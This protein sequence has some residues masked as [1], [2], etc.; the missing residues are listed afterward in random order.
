MRYPPAHS[1][2]ASPA[3]ATGG[4]AACSARCPWH[5]VRRARRQPVAGVPRSTSAAQADEHPG[6]RPREGRR[7]PTRVLDGAPGPLE[8]KPV[9]WIHQTSLLR[10]DAEKS[11]VKLIHVRN[12][13]T[14]AGIGFAGLDQR[15]AKTISPVKPIR[16]NLGD[17]IPACRQVLPKRIQVRRP[18]KSAVH[19]TMAT[20]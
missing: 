2:C 12:E 5:I 1:A 9:L 7:F 11:G 15:I 8:K 10:W 19:P 20:G 6:A 18:R 4:W 3:S 16:R 14:P 13:S 17:Q